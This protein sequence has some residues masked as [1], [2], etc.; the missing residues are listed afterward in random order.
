MRNLLAVLAVCAAFS[1]PAAAGEGRGVAI[2][3]GIGFTSDPTTFL[4]S[5]ELPIAIS[6]DFDL[7][8]LVQLGVGNDRLI[9]APTVNAR[10]SFPLSRYV[11]D[12]DPVWDRLRPI[13]H[14]GLGFA[15]LER[16]RRPGDDDD[17]GFLFNLGLG[18]QYEWTDRV[19][20][21]TRMTFNVMPGEVLDERFFFSWQLAQLRYRF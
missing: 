18:I 11:T 19:S 8:P 14:G 12:E 4:L 1:L 3:T 9:V 13:A 17:L 21:G 15:Y 2:E 16:D 10:Y 7:G 5:T 20:F 6:R